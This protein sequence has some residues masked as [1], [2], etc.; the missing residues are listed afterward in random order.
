MNKAPYTNPFDPFDTYGYTNDT[1]DTITALTKTGL[2][3][4]RNKWH[5]VLVGT[6]LMVELMTDLKNHKSKIFW[7]DSLFHRISFEEALELMPT[8]IRERILFHLDLFL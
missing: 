7:R 5:L 4:Y 1:A 2:F 8:E 6:P 3:G